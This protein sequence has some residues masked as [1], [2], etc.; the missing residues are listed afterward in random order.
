LRVVKFEG[1]DEAIEY[2]IAGW[3]RKALELANCNSPRYEIKKF[4][5]KGDAA[6]EIYFHWE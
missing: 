1:I 3:T 2:R 6:T 5:S 4:L